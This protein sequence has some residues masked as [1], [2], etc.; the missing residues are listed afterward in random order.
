MTEFLF[1]RHHSE[2][3]AGF[4]RHNAIIHIRLTYEEW[5][6]VSSG[7]SKEQDIQFISS[8]SPAIRGDSQSSRRNCRAMMLPTTDIIH[9]L[10]DNMTID[11][12]VKAAIKY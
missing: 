1:V 10:K 8:A 6:G 3:N 2:N 4:W 9:G 7:I 12:R 11:E 5:V